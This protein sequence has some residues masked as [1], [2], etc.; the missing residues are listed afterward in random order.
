[1]TTRSN[2]DDVVAHVEGTGRDAVVMVHGWPDTHRLWDQQVAVLKDRYRC[3]RFTLPGFDLAKPGRAYGLDEVVETIRHVVEQTCPGERVTLL[4][5]D[6]GCF[7]GYQFAMRHPALV[8]R[9]IGVDIGDA[10]SRRNVAAM[11]AK[12]KLMVVG[13][14][15]WLALAW[16]IGGSVGTGMARW[17]ARWMRCPT[18]PDAIGAQMGYPYAVQWFKVKGG[19]GALRAFDPAV[20][21]LFF[22]GARKPFMFHSQHWLDKIAARPGSRVIGLPTGHWVMLQRPAEFNDALQAWLDATDGALT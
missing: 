16:R 12:Q 20:P 19:F 22:Y 17:I 8:Q 14:Q 11:T 15:C 21:M 2:V 10:G 6:W 13:Y 9:V 18:D 4:L 7:Y 3:V 1:M 5:H